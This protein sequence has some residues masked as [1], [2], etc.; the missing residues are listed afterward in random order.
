MKRTFLLSLSL[1]AMSLGASAVPA[2]HM[3]YTM[4]QSDGTTIQVYKH[5]HRGLAYYTTIDGK[6]LRA[7]PDLNDDLCYA[8][9]VDGKIVTSNIVAHDIEQ[10]TAEELNFLST[11]TINQASPEVTA[12][13]ETTNGPKRVHYSSTSDGLGKYGTSALGAVSS[14]GSPKIPV[15]LV[16]YA[17]VKLQEGSTKELYQRIMT[18]EGYTDRLGSVGSV[19]DYF[20]QNSYGMFSPDFQVVATVTLSK[21]RSYYGANRGGDGGDVRATEMVEEA[22]ELAAKQGVDF[23][24]FEVNG[25]IENVIIIYAGMGEASGGSAETIWPH[26]YD[27]QKDI[28]GIHFNSYFVG[29]EINSAGNVDGIGTLVHEF[30]H[31]L[32]LPD[33]YVTNY[34]YN[35][36]TSFGMW[37]VMD[38]GCYAGN[39]Y[40]PTGYTAYE[41][42]YLG[43]LDIPAIVDPTTVTLTDPNTSSTGFAVRVNNPY[44]ISEY[45]IIENRQPGTWYVPNTGGG[46]METH[47]AYNRN[48]WNY[49][50]LNN[51]Q[52]K[53]RCHVITADESQINYGVNVGHLYGNNVNNITRLPLY[54]GVNLDDNNFYRILLHHD[55]TATMNFKNRTF[56]DEYKPTEGKYFRLVKSVD[57]LATGDSV[58][59]VS[60]DNGYAV[61]TSIRDGLATLAAVNALGADQVL[62]NADAQIFAVRKNTNNWSLRIGNSYLSV[63]RDGLAT[64]SSLSNG[65]FNLAINNGDASIEFTA[66]YDKNK[67]S[68]DDQAYTATAVSNNATNLH[69]YKLDTA[70]GID[71]AEVTPAQQ[72]GVREVYNL[73]GQR[74][75]G[76]GKL[77]KGIYIIN[78]KKTVVR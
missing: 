48:Q 19:R 44:S 29:N 12:L 33:F 77:P 23:T 10:R 20:V 69:I 32:G 61:G 73:Q 51:E 9:V 78:G 50:T 28:N 37:S 55:G 25:N 45:F 36:D 38:S 74:V 59:V 75:N 7:N 13:F 52:K 53:K 46:V 8:D 11:C 14:I 34:S 2:K 43:W 22:V 71:A 57:E 42:S 41:K 40:V 47:V 56:S 21:D 24:Q 64:T 39:G 5:G 30:S 27:F 4:K 1:L 58:I 18:E 76:T 3:V 54:S 17:D 6:V 62:T 16:N 70:A 65:R 63:G 68:F 26:E 31:A 15:I 67:L 72:E 60:G 49:N 35:G 66:N